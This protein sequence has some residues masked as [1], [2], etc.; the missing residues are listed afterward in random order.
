MWI[1]R[2]RLP[3]RQIFAGI[4]GFVLGHLQAERAGTDQMLRGA[5]HAAASIAAM[6]H[7]RLIDRRRAHRRYLQL[8]DALVGS[9]S[10]SGK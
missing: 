4:A 3:D 8:V 7:H 1:T 2:G 5:A 10:D 9:G 6:G